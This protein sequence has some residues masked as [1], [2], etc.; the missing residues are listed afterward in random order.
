L[1]LRRLPDYIK[2]LWLTCEMTLRQNVLDGFIIFTV[3]IQPL[4]I[5]VMALWMLRAEGGSAAIFVVV[6]AGMTGLWSS[7]LFISGN[8]INV[9]R[10][11][12]TLEMLVGQPTPFPVIAFG[13]NLA[14][15]MQSLASM[16]LAYVITAVIFGFRLSVADPPL[17]LLALAFTVVAFVSFGLIISPI[18]VMNPGVQGWQNSMEFPVYILSGFLFPI[19]LLPG[20]TTPLSYVLAPYWAAR[21]LHGAS[22]GSAPREEIWFALGMLLVFSV[23]YILVASFL[24]RKMLYKA[25]VDATLGGF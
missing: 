12:G 1:N 11:T 15:V 3:L 16:V 25:R 24:F 6:G 9:E 23:I 7:L 14:H 21:A 10:W 20:W 17:F 18:F 2:A 13:K 22:G 19:A 5:A 8:S 4:I